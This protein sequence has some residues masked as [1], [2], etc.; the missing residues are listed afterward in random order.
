MVTHHGETLGGGFVDI[1]KLEW[2]VDEERDVTA[3]AIAL[4]ALVNEPESDM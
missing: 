3:V 1:P 2:F 4:S